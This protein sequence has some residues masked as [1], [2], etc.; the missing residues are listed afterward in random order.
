V[1]RRHARFC[2]KISTLGCGEVNVSERPQVP[3][4]VR[5]PSLVTVDWG[6]GIVI[7]WGSLR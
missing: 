4:D 3:L 1:R 5:R 6:V 7:D 2:G